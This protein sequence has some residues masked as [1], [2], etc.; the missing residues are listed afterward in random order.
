VASALAVYLTPKS[1]TTRQKVTSCVACLHRLVSVLGEVGDTL[2]V[3]EDS[4]LGET[5][6]P[7]H[8]FDQNTSIVD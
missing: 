5:A 6:H 2:S 4:C 1:S 7:F 8:D 3:C